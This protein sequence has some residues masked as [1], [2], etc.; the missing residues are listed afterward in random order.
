MPGATGPSLDDQGVP[1][2]AGQLP[3]KDPTGDPQEGMT[4]PS[5]RPRASTDW[6]VTADE[7]RAGEPIGVRVE[8]ELPDFSESDAV[9]EVV[10]DIGLTS[11]ASIDDAPASEPDEGGWGYLEQ[12]RIRHDWM[13]D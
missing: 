3:E 12:Q 7:A 8:R 2:L 9:E 1:D 6:G 11:R 5:D 13:N 4:P 10:E